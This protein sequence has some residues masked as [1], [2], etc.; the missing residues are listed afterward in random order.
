MG[1]GDGLVVDEQD[2]LRRLLLA[3]Q[4]GKRLGIGRT[5]GVGDAHGLLLRVGDV[6]VILGGKLADG[7]GAAAAAG[8]ADDLA[9][10]VALEQRLYLQNGRQRGLEIGKPSG[11]AQVFQVVDGEHLAH[12]VAHFLQPRGGRLNVHA[13]VA[14][15]RGLQHQQPL[16]Q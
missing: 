16:P 12:T 2:V 5:V 9:L 7:A 4:G 1:A 15:A 6:F 11:G 8:K 3:E 14:A 13:R 10:R